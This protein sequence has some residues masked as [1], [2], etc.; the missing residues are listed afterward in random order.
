MVQIK[1]IA[2]ECGVSVATVSKSLNDAKDISAATKARVRAC[3]KEMG[4]IPNSAAKALKSS[5]TETIGILFEENQ[6][7]GFTHNHFSRVLEAIKQNVESHGYDVMFINPQKKMSYLQHCKSRSVEGVII[8]C[9]DFENPMAKELVDSY[10]PVVTIDYDYGNKVSIMS[11]N[12]AGGRAIAEC[13]VEMGHTNIGVIHG[14]VTDVTIKRLKGIE[15]VLRE[16]NIPLPMNKKK[17]CVF[18]DPNSTYFVTQELL[19]SPERPTCILFQDDYSYIGGYNAI[20]DAGLSIPEDIS[21]IGYDGINLSRIISPRLVT[22][23]QDCAQIGK[24]AVEK[25]FEQIANPS[26]PIY[27]IV[28]VAGYLLDGGSMRKI[29]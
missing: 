17:A 5:K 21:V 29:K 4:Y 12:Y 13:A 18:N 27:E 20:V 25:I 1:D 22:Y 10:L 23:N 16:N 11:D 9:I 28:E 2:K 6:N 8:V 7:L 3:A 26:T 24:L 15:D 19:K 14:E